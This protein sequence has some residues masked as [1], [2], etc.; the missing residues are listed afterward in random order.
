MAGNKYKIE[1]GVKLD[2]SDLKEQINKLDDKYKN[3]KVKLGVKLDTSDVKE[4]VS[5][6]DNKHRVKL[7]TKLDTSNV[8][9]QVGKLDNKYK[10][11]LGVKL[12]TSDIKEQVAKYNTNKNKPKIELGVKLVDAEKIKKQIQDLGDIKTDKNSLSLNTE[13]LEESL[14]DIS[15]TIKDIKNSIGTL[16][17]DS[18]MKNLLSSINKINSSL[19][20]TSNQFDSIV[21]NLKSLS[22]KDFNFGIN[23]GIGNANKSSNMMGYGRNVRKKVLPELKS[24]VEYLENA[25]QQ[26]L[27]EQAKL[28]QDNTFS[29]V[30]HYGMPLS[31]NRKQKEGTYSNANRY[32]Q[33]FNIE[34]LTNQDLSNAFDIFSAANK[35][36]SSY[37]EKMEGHEKYIEELIKLANTKGMDLSEFYSK[38]SKSATEIINDVTGLTNATDVVEDSMQELKNIFNSGIDVEK[39]S[40]QLD[41]IV[42]DLNEIK[43]AFQG[44]STNNPFDDLTKSLNKLIGRIDY[45][46]KNN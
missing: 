6:L 1:L 42:A 22:G 45:D 11:E 16:D 41:S 38:F 39:L 4:Q 24:Q 17:D 7:D 13:S 26:Y 2:T 33:L 8:R 35:K 31:G 15:S 23:F 46:N 29:K 18:G 14:R 3:N 28:T 44:L 19:E 37:V 32:K 43:I 40:V 20:K 12:T 9:E 10:I 30:V 36:K 34:L 21:D 27:F 5:K 25:I